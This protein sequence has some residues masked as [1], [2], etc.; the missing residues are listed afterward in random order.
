MA[1]FKL[2]LSG[3]ANQWINPIT[4]WWSGN[5]IS[6]NLGESG[7]PETE[8]EILRRVGTYG[9][10]LG[11]ITDAV[12][13]LLQHLPK[14]TSLSAEESEAIKAFEEMANDIAKI[15]ESHKLTALRPRK[16]VAASS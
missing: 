4:S 3:D 15:K 1:L 8:A 2:P 12:V 7:S 6:V 9:R 11:Q 13:V 10:Q 14:H 5:Q 16:S